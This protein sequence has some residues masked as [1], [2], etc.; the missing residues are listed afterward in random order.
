MFIKPLNGIGVL[1]QAGFDYTD[2]GASWSGGSGGLSTI[3]PLNFG[4]VYSDVAVKRV[5][6]PTTFYYAGKLPY[7]KAISNEL[8]YVSEGLDLTWD[9]SKLLTRMSYGTDYNSYNSY[10]AFDVLESRIEDLI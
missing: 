9:E 5:E 4:L 6:T 7:V 3:N 10:L 8:R 1:T 2:L